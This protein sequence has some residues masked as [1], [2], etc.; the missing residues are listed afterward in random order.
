MPCVCECFSKINNKK[1]GKE[2]SIS[3]ENFVDEALELQ[4]FV[5]L[6][7]KI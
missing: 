4:K 2:L 5:N 7:G 1:V 3:F 6:C